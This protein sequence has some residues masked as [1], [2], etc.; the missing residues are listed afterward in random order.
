[1]HNALCFLFEVRGYG[2]ISW[3]SF[4]LLIKLVVCLAQRRENPCIG[5]HIMHWHFV[6]VRLLHSKVGMQ[7]CSVKESRANSTCTKVSGLWHSI[8]HTQAM[9]YSTCVVYKQNMKSSCAK[10]EVLKNT[11]ST[12]T[13]VLLCC[14]SKSK[15]FVL[16]NSTLIVKVRYQAIHTLANTFVMWLLW[17]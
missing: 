2:G 16:G 6:C 14:Y 9:V 5:L 15:Q 12:V 13:V 10:R 3:Q 7:S 1:M 8:R 17:N 4:Q 11:E